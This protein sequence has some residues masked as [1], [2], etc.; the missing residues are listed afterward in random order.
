VIDWGIGHYE[1]T[2]ATILR[3]RNEDPAAF[4]V[5]SPYRVI[6]LRRASA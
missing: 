4:R 3:E 2:V 6:H 1:Q 5:H